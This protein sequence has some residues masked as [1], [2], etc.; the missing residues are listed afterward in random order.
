[1]YGIARKREVDNLLAPR[2]DAFGT[3]LVCTQVNINGCLVR[4]ENQMQHRWN[5]LR[6]GRWRVQHATSNRHERR[7]ELW[8]NDGKTTIHLTKSTP[9]VSYASPPNEPSSLTQMH[10]RT[11]G[12]ATHPAP[13]LRI[14][15]PL[16]NNLFTSS[17][18]PSRRSGKSCATTSLRVAPSWTVIIL[19]GEPERRCRMADLSASRSD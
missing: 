6:R 5:L 1:M 4:L 3:L 8:H 17:Y 15:S 16:V 13:T 2:H 11:R 19:E 10:A 18:N 7:E 9:P 14:V 12:A